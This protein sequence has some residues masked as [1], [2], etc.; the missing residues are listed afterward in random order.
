MI[1]VCSVP[2]DMSDVKLIGDSGWNLMV[3]TMKIL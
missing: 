1:M 2:A 3:M